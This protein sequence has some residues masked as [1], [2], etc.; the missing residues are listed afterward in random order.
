MKCPRCGTDN[1][2]G[3]SFCT[4][5]GMPL[6]GFNQSTTTTQTTN[7]QNNPQ[8]NETNNGVNSNQ[9]VPT[10]SPSP[11]QP[12]TNGNKNNKITIGIIIGVLVLAIIGLAIYF[13]VFHQEESTTQN[14]NNSSQQETE[15][16]AT[17]KSFETTVGEDDDTVT[18]IV[19]NE[20]ADSSRSE[21]SDT[22]KMYFS[23][24]LECSTIS[25][26]Y[27][28]YSSAQEDADFYASNPYWEGVYEVQRYNVTLNNGE[29]ALVVQLDENMGAIYYPLTDTSNVEIDL[30]ANNFSAETIQKYV[31]VKE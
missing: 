5:C 7:M 10:M 27:S 31:V 23:T 13:L 3:A 9:P 14:N 6:S 26:M 4:A 2:E 20:C 25:F 19:Q 12:S 22:L 18:F 8:Q 11:Q 15:Q 17:G 30:T 1:R 29:E 21:D 24:N 28:G 16:Q